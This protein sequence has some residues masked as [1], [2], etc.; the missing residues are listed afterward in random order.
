[1]KAPVHLPLNLEGPIQVRRRIR[2][3]PTILI[4]I[5]SAVKT[6][7]VAHEGINS[8]RLR[9][10]GPSRGNDPSPRDISHMLRL[11]HV[12]TASDHNYPRATSVEACRGLTHGHPL[13][14]HDVGSSVLR[15]SIIRRFRSCAHNFTFHLAEG[16]TSLAFRVLKWWF[17]WLRFNAERPLRPSSEVCASARMHQL[18]CNR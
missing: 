8:E 14:G 1:V 16:G 3:Q 10:V 4:Y 15:P 6:V 18:W 11:L 5:D 9:E 12:R 17:P 2:G 7:D 13:S